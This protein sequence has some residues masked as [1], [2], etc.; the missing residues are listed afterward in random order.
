MIVWLASYPKSG[1]TWVRLFLKAYFSDQNTFNINKTIKD[2]LHIEKFPNIEQFLK[3]NINYVNFN[4]IVKNWTLIQDKI[5]LQKK[6][7]FYKTHNAL[8]TINSHPFTN[9][10]NSLGI[11]YIVRDPRDVA[12]SYSHHLGTTIDNT[13]EKMI[14]SSNG[15]YVHFKNKSFR[16]SIIGSWSDH[17]NSWTKTKLIKYH[18]VKYENLI[19]NKSLEFSK[20]IDFLDNLGALK[21]DKNKIEFSINQTQFEKLQNLERIQGFEEKSSHTKS[22]FRN[23]K[24]GEGKNKLNKSQRNILE[25]KFEKEMKE[26][27]YLN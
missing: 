13:I 11:I 5:N 24:I 18:L 26:L 3:M 8:C 22:F 20:I 12:I 1:N 19:E 14:D 10:D 4:E 9:K 21:K 6:I 7:N 17:F 23:G 15:E 2:V 27:N 25:K 16:S